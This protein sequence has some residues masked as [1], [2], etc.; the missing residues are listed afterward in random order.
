M[1]NLFIKRNI[2]DNSSWQAKILCKSGK[3][4]LSVIAGPYQYST[5]REFLDDPDYSEV[6]IAI[7]RNSDNDWASKE[8]AS[9]VFPIIG[10]GEYSYNYGNTAVFPY[11]P[12][13]LVLKCTELL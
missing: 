1:K 9:P 4:Y 12:I 10:E 7:F 6:E 3:F 5:P 11:V 8:E 13:D 2:L